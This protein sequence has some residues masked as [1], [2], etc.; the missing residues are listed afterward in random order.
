MMT[1][2][3]IVDVLNAHAEGI[4]IEAGNRSDL[5]WETV[6]IDLQYLVNAIGNGYLFRIK[7][8]KKTIVFPWNMNT[9]PDIC[10]VQFRDQE[11]TNLIIVKH[12]TGV[13]LTTQG[14]V[15]YERLA[16]KYLWI[17]DGK[18]LP[19]GTIEIN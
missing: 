18:K 9:V 1:C 8:P 14:D 13:Y 17:K 12:K 6:N 5:T 15:S 16:E 11:Q 2:K 3:E 4:A 10:W 7:Q 19:C